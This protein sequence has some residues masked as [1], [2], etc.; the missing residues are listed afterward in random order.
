MIGH[1]ASNPGDPSP[2]LLEGLSTLERIQV[3]RVFTHATFGLRGKPDPRIASLSGLE[4]EVSAFKVG[5]G[6]ALF[7]V[8][9]PLTAVAIVVE[10]P[11][12]H[13]EPAV[14]LLTLLALIVVSAAIFLI[15][16][17][18]LQRY[19]AERRTLPMADAD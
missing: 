1:A 19:I 10:G 8:M 9:G 13:L 15:R 16:Y 6:A 3:R 17:R 18:S 4:R 5:V 2:E 11:V 7:M 14:G 12:L